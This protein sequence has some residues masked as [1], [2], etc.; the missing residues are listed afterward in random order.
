[1]VASH[2][3]GSG[4][5]GCWNSTPSLRPDPRN[6]NGYFLADQVSIRYFDQTKDETVLFVG[7]G[8]G[9]G[10]GTGSDNTGTGFFLS[11]LRDIIVSSCGSTVWCIDRSGIHRIDT[12][13]RQISTAL[14]YKQPRDWFCWDR[15]PHIKPDS[16]FYFD[17]GNVKGQYNRFDIA[18][19]AAAAAS[20]ASTVAAN[21]NKQGR[22][23]GKGPG[24]GRPGVKT[25]E[26]EE[27]EDYIMNVVCTQS[28]HLLF[29]ILTKRSAL[30]A[31]DPI[32]CDLKRLDSFA[33]TDGGL[34][35][36]LDDST[37]RLITDEEGV[38]TTYTLPPEYFAPQKCCERDL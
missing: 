29:T 30:Y 27:I 19:A 25:Y 5:I 11:A 28:G 4:D 38:I 8:T 17:A 26:F 35:L 33:I 34:G 21:D 16:A 6:P 22:K 13:T 3:W 23:K 10:T 15:S 2:F 18:A 37:R 1:M 32:S 12:A 24:T 20:T 7:T 9:T 31:V 14:T 36:L